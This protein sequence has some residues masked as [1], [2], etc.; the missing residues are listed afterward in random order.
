MVRYGWKCWYFWIFQVSCRMY[1][2][3]FGILC[4]T[5]GK[6]PLWKWS[7]PACT[8]V[9]S[10]PINSNNEVKWTN[11]AWSLETK[12]SITPSCNTKNNQ[13]K[14]YPQLGIP[15]WAVSTK[16]QIVVIFRESQLAQKGK[17]VKKHK[18]KKNNQNFKSNNNKNNNCWMFHLPLQEKPNPNKNQP[19]PFPQLFT[20]TFIQRHGMNI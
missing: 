14:Q 19:N 12:S 6:A 3:G 11:F 5:P 13:L 15:S 9:F 20:D 2:K 16:S 4:R 17:N 1:E 18:N 10:Q 7:S 8:Y